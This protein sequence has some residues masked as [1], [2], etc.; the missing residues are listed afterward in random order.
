MAGNIKGITVEIGGDVTGLNK[1]LKKADTTINST[2]K[3]LKE[4]TRLL[5]L[6]PTNTTLLQQKQELLSKAIGDTKDK[7]AALQSAKAKA[8]Q[9][10]ANGTEVNQKQYRELCREIEA[11]GL[12]VE[13]LEKQ[14][15]A[16][17]AALDKLAANADKV[18]AGADKVA[19]AT[20]ALSTAA[21][22][23]LVVSGKFAADFEDTFAKVSTLLDESSTDYEAYKNDIIKASDETGVAVTDFG[24]AVYSAISASVDQADAVS[25]TTQAVKLAKGGFTDATKAVDVMTT[26]LNGYSD[27]SLTSEKVSDLLITTQNLGK[28]TV[29]ELASSMGK[30]IPV[31]SASNFSMEELSATY[32]DL[33][34]NGIATAEAGTY[35]KSMLNELTKSGSVADETL[36]ELTGKGF[37]QLKAD[38]ASTTDILKML[39]VEAANNDKTLKDMFSSV[40]AGSAAMVL[41]KGDGAEYNEILQQMRQSAGATENAFSKVAGTTSEQIKRSLNEVKNLSIELGGTLLPVVQDVVGWFKALVEH[42][43]GMDE[44]QIK[45]LATI[46]LV[47]AAISPVAKIISGIA[48]GI[49]LA[50]SAVNTVSAAIAIASSAAATGTAAATGLAGAITAIKTVITALSGP[51]GIAIAAITALVAG[52]LYLW[53]NCESFRA[54]WLALWDGIKAAFAGA[55]TALQDGITGLCTWFTTA[56]DNLK[57]ATA[58]AWNAIKTGVVTLWEN[59]RDGVIAIVTPFIGSIQTAW[60]TFKGYISGMMDGLKNI[61]TGIW[62]VIKNLVLGTVL[63]LCDLLTGDFDNLKSHIQSIMQNIKNEISKI[64]DG[65]RQY[66]TSVMGM[67]GTTITNAWNIFLSTI[68][69]LCNNIKSNILSVWNGVISW[70]QMLPGTLYNI[71]CNM[72]NS[73]RNGVSSTIYGVTNAIRNGITNAVNFIRS[74]PG[75]AI[76]WGRDFMIGFANGIISAANAVLN[77]VRSIASAIASYLHFSR[78]D[79]GPLRD[80]ESWPRDFIEGYA[81][82][83]ENAMPYLQKAMQGVSGSMAALTTGG[84]ASLAQTGKNAATTQ[85]DKSVSLGGVKIAVY[86]QDG[87]SAQEIANEVMSRMESAVQRKA[88]VFG[89]A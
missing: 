35:T 33:T 77:Q 29:D 9:D 7:L 75:Q 25:F 19:D 52:F 2:Q 60:D 59:I 28:T 68:T 82:G 45:T 85:I 18:A 62:E 22:G 46:L 55:V 34:R 24:E 1:A 13:G 88:A 30:V 41:A 83:I 49:S 53:N 71:A 14:A 11:T 80:Y 20:Q 27:A 50:T 70:F 57:A 56:W 86:G 74:L 16:G 5:K 67:I 43:K 3:E 15:G 10:M 72:F 17:S 26:A 6:D 79:K 48:S 39:S 38:G 81:D 65:I 61:F 31:A 89:G 66:F 37:A 36:R 84:T 87:H 73:M 54:F 8:D 51:I 76:G 44:A 78:P 47:V 64:W 4:V 42:L 21:A 69:N 32:A 12:Q 58:A 40:E 63:L 23:V